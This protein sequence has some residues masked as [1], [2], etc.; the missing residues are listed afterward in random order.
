MSDEIRDLVETPHAHD[1]IGTARNL[2]DAANAEQ[3]LEGYAA[4]NGLSDGSEIARRAY[5]LFERRQREGAE[6][7]A[8]G[9]WFR[10]E[11]EVRRGRMATNM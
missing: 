10:A 3:S 8:D 4:V 9:D 6:G 7:S 11:E 2:S 1:G 5:E